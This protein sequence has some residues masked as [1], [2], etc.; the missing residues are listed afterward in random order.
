M[1]EGRREGGVTW[2]TVHIPH[3]FENKQLCICITWSCE[4]IKT[5]CV[6]VCV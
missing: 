2:S 3:T 6:C 5:E 4:F 1:G